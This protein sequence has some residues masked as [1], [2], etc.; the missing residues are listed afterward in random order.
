MA[1]DKA[2]DSTQLNAGLAAIADAIRTKGGTSA[3][4]AFPTGFS[5]A[6]AAIQTGTADLFGVISIG[7]ALYP[8]SGME[9]SESGTSVILT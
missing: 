1:Y 4:L 7:S 3:P 9:A 8:I 6:V 5:S 2:V